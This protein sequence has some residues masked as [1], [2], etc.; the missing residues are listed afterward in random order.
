MKI[1][2]NCFQIKKDSLIHPFTFIQYPLMLVILRRREFLFPYIMIQVNYK[3]QS[4]MVQ[5]GHYGS[6]IKHYQ[7][8]CPITFL[9]FMLMTYG[10]V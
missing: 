2:F 4:Q 7:I 1:W 5:L 9:F 10:K 8:I 6:M 3:K